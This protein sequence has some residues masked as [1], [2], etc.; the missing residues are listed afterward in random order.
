VSIKGKRV[1]FLGA[2]NMGEA[3]IKGLLQAGLVH[4]QTICAT[5]VRADRLE[6]DPDPRVDGDPARRAR[7][8]ADA[9]A[10]PAAA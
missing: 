9:A 2:G 7:S 10:F 6:R 3:M 4:A 1:G 8:R 5:D